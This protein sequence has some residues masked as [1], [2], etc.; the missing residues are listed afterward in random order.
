MA[1]AGNDLFDPNIRGSPDSQGISVVE[2]QFA[3]VLSPHTAMSSLRTEGA[4]F[5]S[6]ARIIGR[7]SS[8]VWFWFTDDSDPQSK[9]SAT[10][11][12]CKLVVNHHR[13]SEYAKTHL[14]KCAP[15]RRLMMGIELA[16][17]P[18]WFK[19][20]MTGGKLSAG[21]SIPGRSCFQGGF[22][23]VPLPFTGQNFNNGSTMTTFLI[24]KLSKSDKDRFQESFAMHYYATGTSFLRVEDCHLRTAIKILRP[25]DDVLP[26]RK[27]LG[28]TL[29]DKCHSCLET[30]VNAK[31]NGMTSCLT[32]DGWTNIKNDAIVNYMAV[33]PGCC[34]FLESVPTGQ[35]GH[36]HKFIAEDIARVIRHYSSTLFAGAVTDNTSTNKKAWKLLKDMFPSSYFQGCCAHGLHLLVKDIFGATKTRKNGEDAPT[37]PIGYPFE[38]MQSFVNDCREVVKYFHNHHVPKA[39]LEELQG[40]TGARVLIRPAPTRWGTIQHMC[41]TLLESERHLY[42]LVTERD[43]VKGTISQ[44][45]E[46]SKVKDIVS[47]NR[48]VDMLKKALRILS[49]IDRL[50]VKYQC[51]KVPISDVLPDFDSLPSAFLNEFTRNVIV[52]EELN[53]L[54]DATQKRLMFMFGEAH[55]VSNLLDPRHLGA[56]LHPE[57]PASRLE[58]QDALFMTPVDDVTLVTEERKELLYKE[59]TKFFMHATLEKRINSFRHKCLMKGL[60]TPLEYWHIEGVQWPELQRIAIKLFSMAT[61][62]AASERNFSTMGFI[63]SKLRNGLNPKTVE[64]LVYIKTNMTSFFDV[65]GKKQEEEFNLEEEEAEEATEHSILE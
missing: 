26:S 49:P 3:G 59:Y 54:V 52:Q 30:K 55:G 48:F 51:D 45:A 37:Y 9:K 2:V 29:L 46:C 12:N 13:K 57:G 42:S 23:P 20:S 33:S 1:T 65:P 21:L 32:T 44:K 31:M 40:T 34:L 53:Y 15:F 60:S 58:A 4:S 38:G 50:I 14:N 11:K 22:A 17:R 41:S 56:Q 19:S 5:V 6:P 25:D 7:A 10:C 62:S 35:Q 63:H 36:N 61:S 18:N 16:Q 27:Q 47:N 39:Q 64:K 28:T 8:A 24:P 43:F